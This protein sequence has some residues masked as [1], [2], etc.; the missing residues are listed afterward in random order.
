[1]GAVTLGGAESLRLI[2]E[3]KEDADRALETLRDLA[4]GIYPPLL[5][6]RGLG[7]ALEAQARRSAIPVDVRVDVGRHTP[8]VE[9]SIYFC[10]VEAMQNAVKHS[11]GSHVEITVT[12]TGVMVRFAVHD[13]GRGFDAVDAAPSGGLQTMDDRL[14]A[15]DGSLVVDSSPDDGTWVRGTVPVAH[16]AVAG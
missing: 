4:R 12:E 2:S 5:A 11:G 14:Q 15:L 16:L 1:M 7:V 9:S 3:L 6:E 10:C 8:E 13:D